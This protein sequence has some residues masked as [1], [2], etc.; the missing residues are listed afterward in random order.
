MKFCEKCGKELM[1]ETV[2]CP[3]CGYLVN[4]VETS[5]EERVQKPAGFLAKVKQFGIVKTVGLSLLVVLCVVL[6]LSV[7]EGSKAK[8]AEEA[9]KEY[10]ANVEEYFSLSLTAGAN[11][12]DI[13]DTVQAYWYE[14]IFEDKHGN[15]IN[16]AIAY[17]L[18]DKSAEISEAETYDAQMK[19]LY[20]KIK[21]VPDGISED[22]KYEIEGLCD[23]VK[24]LHDVYTDFYSIATDPSGSYN[25][26]SDDNNETTDEFLSCYHA[27]ENLLD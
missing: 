24:D 2:I 25:S 22:D 1:D 18:I 21:S 3:E 20:S 4:K 27:L 14:N 8:N 5:V 12:E 16:D 13:A 17:A 15:D 11:L 7:V 10:I 23:A 26:Y 19:D 6:I 9:K